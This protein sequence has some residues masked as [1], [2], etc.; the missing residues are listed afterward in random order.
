MTTPGF[1]DGPGAREAACLPGAGPVRV[2]TDLAVLGF[3]PASLR[4]RIDALYPGVSVDDVQSRCG[5]ELGVPD[6]LDT[7]TAPT[8]EQLHLLRQVIDPEGVYLGA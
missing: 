3:D 6:S 8:G 4:M 1:L 5:F 7:F 2:I